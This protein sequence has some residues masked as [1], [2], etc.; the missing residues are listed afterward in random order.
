[1]IRCVIAILLLGLLIAGC[2]PPLAR[3]QVGGTA[4]DLAQL[5]GEW[6]GDYTGASSGRGGSIHFRLT[7]GADTASG[8]VVMVPRGTFEALQP[9]RD[10]GAA[11]APR[12]SLPEPLTITFVRVAVG[13]VT[14]VLDPYRDPE[15]GCTLTTT[16]E[17]T[18]QGD[19]IR[20]TFESRGGM[21]HL[22]QSGT[23]QVRRKKTG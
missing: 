3:V 17:G 7:A 12:S 10:P 23:W 1:M 11:A 8:E 2:A 6:E 19:V 13:K 5:A 14:G 9:A 21:T 18:L 20:G 22:P 16:F 15:C 4:A